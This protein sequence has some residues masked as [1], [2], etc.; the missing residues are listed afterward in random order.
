LYK[1]QGID[2]IS[3]LRGDFSGV[4]YDK[5]EKTVKIFTNHIGSKPIYYFWDKP[6]RTLIFCSELKVVLNVMRD[7]GFRTQLSEIGAY[8]LL[9][10]GYMLK[11]Y[12]LC[13]N[14]KKLPAGTVLT[15]NLNEGEISFDKYYQL[16][17]T[18]Y[19]E[20]TRENIIENLDQKFSDAVKKEYDKDIEYGYRHVATLSGGLDSR[21]NVMKGEMLGYKNILAINLSQNNYL[22]ELIAKNIASDH[23]YDFLFFSLDNGNFLKNIEKPV[24]AN[25]GQIFFAGSAHLLAMLSLIDW[26]ELGLL[27]TGQI[28]DLVLGSYLSDR[29]H[30]KVSDKI[31]FKTAY[32]SKLIDRIPKHIFEEMVQQYESDEMFAFY[33]RCVNGVFNGNFMTYHYTEFSSPFLYLDF[34]EYAMRIHPRLRYKERIY[35]DWIQIKVPDAAEYIWEKTGLPIAAGEWRVFLSNVVKHIKRKICGT[36]PKD[37]M[38]PFDHWFE[39]NPEL[40]NVFQTY[41]KSH[42]SL[43]DDYQTLKSDARI[44]FEK[45]NTIEKSQVLTLLAAIKLFGLRN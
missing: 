27:H 9:S 30:F 38:N 25:D 11:D 4:I 18:P 29:Q 43:L 37:S 26:D 33:E 40:R 10:F 39:T 1:K 16:K 3:Q 22:D 15:C 41:F 13:E 23:G 21:I 44:M 36:S 2:L 14:V 8:C 5:T 19:I 20:D 34:L 7:F 42:I 17:N 31:I 35:L 32:S 24:L 28:G 45:G 6:S 12:T